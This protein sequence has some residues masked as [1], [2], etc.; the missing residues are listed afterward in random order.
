MLSSVAARMMRTAISARLAAIIFLKGGLSDAGPQFMSE[1]SLVTSQGSASEPV[2]ATI[3]I[4]LNLA[5][6]AGPL[7]IVARCIG[8]GIESAA[9]SGDASRICS[10]WA[11]ILQ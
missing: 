4:G 3:W 2:V 7:R 6:A 8:A 5:A 11:L 1:T 10:I 9:N